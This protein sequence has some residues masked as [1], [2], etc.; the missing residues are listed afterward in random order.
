MKEVIT[1]EAT[2]SKYTDNQV[3]TSYEINTNNIKVNNGTIGTNNSTDVVLST[4]N[5]EA[6]KNNLK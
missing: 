4:T 1:F 2:K 3:F 5:F 6:L